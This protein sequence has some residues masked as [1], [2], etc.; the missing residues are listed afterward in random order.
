MIVAGAILILVSA[1]WFVDSQKQETKV[2][3]TTAAMRVPHPDIARINVEDAKAAFDMDTAVFIDTRGDSYYSQGHIPGAL[4]I[5]EEQLP[6]HLD[7][8]NP[9]DLIITYCT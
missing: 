4:S 6:E 9:A 8:L 3:Q 1:A 2:S 5:T 7:D